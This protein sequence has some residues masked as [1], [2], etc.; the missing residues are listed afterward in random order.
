MSLNDCQKTWQLFNDTPKDRQNCTDYFNRNDN[1]VLLEARR[2]IQSE[3]ADCL[4]VVAGDKVKK[5]SQKEAIALIPIYL[6]Q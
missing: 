3:G 4:A 6:L 5:L 2:M 1:V